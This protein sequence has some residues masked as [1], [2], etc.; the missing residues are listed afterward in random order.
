MVTL[1]LALA[2][3]LTTLPT[4]CAGSEV[5]ATPSLKAATRSGAATRAAAR[6]HT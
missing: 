2:L 3:A 5:P 1:D 4:C 6:V